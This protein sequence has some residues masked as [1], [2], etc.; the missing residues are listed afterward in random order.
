MAASRSIPDYNDSQRNSEP[1]DSQEYY[2]NS[3]QRLY[4]PRY[5]N[6]PLRDSGSGLEPDLAE[7]KK[8]IG[9]S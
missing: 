2:E 4:E 1:L 7:Q 3:Q 8:M 5:N 6:D 9:G